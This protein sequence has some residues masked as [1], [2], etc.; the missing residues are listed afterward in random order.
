MDSNQIKRKK[1][2]ESD[3]FACGFCGI[4]YH[5]DFMSEHFE[6][7]KICEKRGG[8]KVEGKVF[9]VN[10]IGKDVSDAMRFGTLV[11]VTEGSV[12]IFN[13]DRVKFDLSDTL[14]LHHFDNKND[15]IL[16]S[17]STVLN[18]VIG[19]LAAKYGSVNILI[20]DAKR[21]EYAEREVKI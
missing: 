6:V 20:W 15:Y 3:T 11:P 10:H 8:D 7:C 12:N 18:F 5:T 9:I 4:R 1:I 13:I 21:Q 17:G 16:L 2:N 19:M 14:D